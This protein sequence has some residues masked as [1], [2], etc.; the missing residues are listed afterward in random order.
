[1]VRFP[2]NMKE[3]GELAGRDEQRARDNEERWTDFK[4]AATKKKERKG[5]EKE[6]S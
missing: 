4:E 5:N 6:E 1:M 2:P 3:G